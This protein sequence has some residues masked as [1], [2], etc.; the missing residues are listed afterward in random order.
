MPLTKQEKDN[1]QA[2]LDICN[3]EKSTFFE[4]ATKA[5]LR[6]GMLSAMKCLQKW[7]QELQR[8]SKDKGLMQVEMGKI[9]KELAGY[10]PEKNLCDVLQAAQ[11]RQVG[12]TKGAKGFRYDVWLESKERQFWLTLLSKKDFD[13]EQEGF[14]QQY[15]HDMVVVGFREVKGKQGVTWHNKHPGYGRTF[16]RGIDY[17]SHG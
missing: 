15:L 4:T 6:E 7:E 17:R 5:E 9:Q 3:E 13:L 11:W 10:L 2:L 8:L 16:V 14:R 1:Y 12:K